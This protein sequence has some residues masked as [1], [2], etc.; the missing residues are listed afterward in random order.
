M[1][2]M[3]LSDGIVDSLLS[4][5]K[6]K[7]YTFVDEQAYDAALPVIRDRV[8]E[9]CESPLDSQIN[10]DGI[11]YQKML[12]IASSVYEIAVSGAISCAMDKID[13]ASV[14]E[15][16]INAMDVRDLE[17][18]CLTVMKK[19]LSSVVYLGGAIGFIIGIINIFI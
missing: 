7:V 15:K 18:L 3:F 2:G 1:L 17:A 14:V 11:D 12:K 9:F 8:A 4:Q 10:F 19:E 5:V 16:K 6:E 13:I